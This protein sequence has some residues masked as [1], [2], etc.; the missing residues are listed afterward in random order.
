MGRGNIN[1]RLNGLNPLAYMG[2]NAFQPPEFVT[3]NRPPTANDSFN[4]ELG[5]LWL[6]VASNTPPSANDVY[7]LVALNGGVATWVSVGGSDLETLTGNSGG[8]VSPD[9]AMNINIVGNGT[10]ITVVGNPGTNTLTISAVGTGLVSTLTGNSGGAVP[11]TAGNINVIGTGVITVVGNPGTSTLTVTPSGAIASSFITN[12]ATGTATPSAGVLTFAGAGGTVVSAAGSTVT[13]TG[14]GGTVTTLHTQDGNNVTPTAGVINISGAHG[15]N[16]TGTV[17]PNTV[18]VAINNAIT[19]GDLTPLAADAGAITCTTGDVIITAGDLT[20]PGTNTA[21]NQGIIKFGGQRWISCFPLANN[22]TF[23]G[24]VA[25]NTTTT[26]SGVTAIGANAL[27]SVTTGIDNTCIGVS[28]GA[29]VTTGGFNCIMGVQTGDRITTGGR[30]TILGQSAVSNALGP[31]GLTTGNDNVIIGYQAGLNYTSSESGNIIIGAGMSGV[32][33]E[34]NKTKIGGIR[35]A[36]TTNADAIAVLIDSAGQ[37]GTVSSSLRYKEN[38]HDMGI[39]SDDIYRLRPV[40]FNYKKHSPGSKSYGLIAEEVEQVM[41]G[42]V[43]YDKEGQP[44]TIKYHELP[45]LLLNE[46]QKKDLIIDN[47]LQRVTALE[48]RLS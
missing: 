5:T 4:F 30:N 12:P 25:G 38:I 23:V 3:D 17:G 7:M 20:L 44:D 2:D 13:I 45:I 37:L 9:G 33:G 21:G 19:L 43:V 35:G 28:A 16:T 40:V 15:L 39:I 22:N 10:T 6:D 34:S 1:Q 36:T 42:L 46:L 14:S 26:A 48:S 47:L 8:P 32:V 31:T 29:S 18:T 41:P 11:P 24:N 27:N